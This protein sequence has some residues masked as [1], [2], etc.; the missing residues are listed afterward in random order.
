MLRFTGSSSFDMVSVRDGNVSSNCSKSS[1][2]T[3]MSAWI[4]G[5][6]AMMVGAIRMHFFRLPCGDDL[7]GGL[8]FV[9]S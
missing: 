4:E 1:Q 3:G 8:A 5:S 6:D 9:L 2:Q 7:V